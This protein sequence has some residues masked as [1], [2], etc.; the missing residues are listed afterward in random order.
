VAGKRFYQPSGQ[1]REAE[2]I[3]Y[4]DELKKKMSATPLSEE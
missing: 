1:G 3:R 2:I 4:L